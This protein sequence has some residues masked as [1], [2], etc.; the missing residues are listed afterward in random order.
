MAYGTNR[1][2]ISVF[3]SMIMNHRIFSFDMFGT[4]VNIL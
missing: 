4:L 3:S 2:S 1:T